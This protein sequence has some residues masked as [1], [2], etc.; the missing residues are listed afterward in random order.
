MTKTSDLPPL[1]DHLNKDNTIILSGRS[2]HDAAND[3]ENMLV[4]RGAR[5][6]QR[7]ERLVRPMYVEVPGYG[8]HGKARTATFIP[9]TDMWLH[10]YITH[11]CTFVKYNTYTREWRMV[12]NPPIQLSQVIMAN[13]GGWP[14]EHVI[15]LLTCPTLRPDGSILQGRGYDRTTGLL[16]MHAP[17]VDCPIDPRRADAQQGLD[18]LLDLIKEFPAVSEV[19]RSVLLSALI[20]PVVAASLPNSPLHVIAAPTPGT[21][22][23]YF[24]DLCS[25]IVSGKPCPIIAVG[26]NEEETEK[27]LGAAMLAGYPLLSIDNVNGQLGGDFLCQVVER[28]VT[29]VRLLGRSSIVQISKNI[30]LFAT[31]NNIRLVGDIT[32]RS[33]IAGLDP[34]MEQPE[35]R[36]FSDNPIQKVMAS[37]PAYI[38][39]ILNIVRAWVANT[40]PPSRPGPKQ[41]A[42]P[43][44]GSA[45]KTPS[46]LSPR[47][48]RAIPS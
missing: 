3:V 6:Y 35:L 11:F 25:A 39:A 27:R 46:P 40:S 12:S 43:S 21:G 10:R 32:R 42:P 24:V 44:S 1:P 7:A 45:W 48:V 17:K 36:S 29:N 22:K 47:P 14:F 31:G 28:P 18:L 4:Q 38:E 13:A 5:I 33:I 26:R 34:K 20:T 2:L 41:F 30:V 15:G 37:R 8:K 9:V 23:S 16:M 19:D